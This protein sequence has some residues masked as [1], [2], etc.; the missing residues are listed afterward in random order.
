MTR[1]REQRRLPI[2]TI[3]RLLTGST[4][5]EPTE[6]KT[7]G[8]DHHELAKGQIDEWPEDASTMC[9][10]EVCQQ[11]FVSFDLLY[12]HRM[13]SDVEAVRTGDRFPGY[14]K[15]TAGDEF[16][17]EAT[18]GEIAPCEPVDVEEVSDE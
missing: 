17:V 3:K 1:D 8:V 11:V 18:V 2:N 4:D 13:A 5:D 9:Y 12:E 7:S 10:C 6:T 14:R 15:L 16:P